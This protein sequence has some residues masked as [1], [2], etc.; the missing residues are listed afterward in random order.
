MQRLAEEC[1]VRLRPHA[2]SH[3]SLTIGRRQLEHGATGLCVAKTGEAAVFADAGFEDLLV[4]YPTV[5]WRAEAAAEL[6]ERHPRLRLAVAIDSLDGVRDLARAVAERG[7]TLTVWIKIDSGLHRAGL[8]PEDPSLVD[9]ARLVHLSQGLRLRGLLTHGGHVYRAQ[10][11]EVAA[12]GRAEAESMVRAAA[13]LTE[14]GLGPIEVGLGATPS[15]A[16]AARVPGVH[17]IHPGVYVFGDRQQVALG[18]TRARRCLLS[19]LATVVSR[20]AP[21]R[22]I[23]D[24]GSKTLSSD[25]GAHGS[26]LIRGFGAVQ[27]VEAHTGAVSSSGGTAWGEGAAVLGSAAWAAADAPLLSRLSEEHGVIED[28]RDWGWAPGD[29]VEIIPNHA[30]PVVNL[31]EYLYV[32]EGVGA[33]RQ[34]VAMW[35]VEARGRVQ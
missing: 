6:A 32:T 21:G 29:L 11:E 8:A 30:C 5:G 10:P 7:V 15:I 33:E 3:K 34:V 26:E 25:R 22:W 23:V 20:P 31:A 14:A 19:V 27:R 2:K 28:N 12:I 35:P 9:L 17:E 16:S 24:A 1:G 13:R 4:A 18:G